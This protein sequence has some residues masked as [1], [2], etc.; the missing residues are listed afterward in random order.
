MR[1]VDIQDTSPEFQAFLAFLGDRIELQGWTG[2][3][4]DLDVKGTN[5]RTSKVERERER[6]RELR[7]TNICS[8]PTAGATGVYS[9]Y[10]KWKHLEIMYEVAPYMEGTDPHRRKALIGNTIVT[11]VFQ[12]SGQFDP[13]ELVSQVLRILFDYCS[14]VT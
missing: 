13:G 10:K 8:H 6:E 11:I 5:K 14:P 9:C 3:R 1:R 4:G 7:L 2:Y 12:D